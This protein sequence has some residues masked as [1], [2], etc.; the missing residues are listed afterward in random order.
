[1]EKSIFNKYLEKLQPMKK[2]ID[3]AP[4]GSKI[5]IIFHNHTP[6][7]DND[8][9]AA[10][11]ALWM[12]FHYLK[13]FPNHNIRLLAVGECE[14]RASKIIKYHQNILNDDRYKVE[15]I[16]EPE[17][18][19]TIYCNQLYVLDTDFERSG[20]S[21]KNFKVLDNIIV[22]DHHPKLDKLSL[23][24]EMKGIS[25]CKI[26]QINC[27]SLD[28][29]TLSSSTSQLMLALLHLLQSKFDCLWNDSDEKDLDLFYKGSNFL[30]NYYRI[31]RSG[32]Q[33][34][35]GG[36]GYSKTDN[37]LLM[38]GK[39]LENFENFGPF[40]I[41]QA[42][43]SNVTSIKYKSSDLSTIQSIYDKIEITE[44]NIVTLICDKKDFYYPT[45]KVIS[46]LSPISFCQNFEYIA[47]I[48][49]QWE[50]QKDHSYKG[51]IQCRGIAEKYNVREFAMRYG[52]GGHILASGADIIV[53]K[54]KALEHEIIGSKIISAFKKYIRE[55]CK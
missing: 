18:M 55:E 43:F 54:E 5:C 25:T 9:L 42:E 4:E 45:L 47:C 50:E 1:M 22:L 49:L 37:A 27:S 26:D 10:A 20:F 39:F 13:E 24:E 17:M 21:S 15:F 46:G 6:K 16:I 31:L 11:T 12:I 14:E 7:A 30:K 52:G 34:D 40:E 32:I 33:T 3:T 23:L 19:E 2:A 44:E 35:T 8:T 36:F 41:D 51:Y 48:S 38:V 53:P 29:Q 28:E